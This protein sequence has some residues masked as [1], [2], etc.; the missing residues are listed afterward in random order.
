MQPPEDCLIGVKE[1]KLR[2]T[3]RDLVE[4]LKISCIPLYIGLKRI[5]HH[6]TLVK[7]ARRIGSSLVNKILNIRQ[8]STVG[9]DAT[10]FELESKSFYYRNINQDLFNHRRKTKR[11]M[12]L[13]IAAD[14]DRQLI[15]CHRVRRN[16]KACNTEFRD[17]LKELKISYVVADKG[18]SS[19]ENRRFVLNNLHA[20]PI[21]PNKKNEGVYRFDNWRRLRFDEKIY[22]QRSKI[23]TI[24]SVIKRRY[25][26]VLKGRSF[27]TQ[28]DELMCKLIAYNID[29]LAN[30]YLLII[31]FQHSPL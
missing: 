22:H 1:Q 23:E 6:T 21:I 27:I 31:G 30:F 24:F 3:Y 4:L 14:M 16:Y 20:I 29:R 15:L 26:S 9:I 5:P 17:M 25:G 18:Y 11:F 19:K 8:A 13:S 28:K 12:K 7:F 2:T 10:G